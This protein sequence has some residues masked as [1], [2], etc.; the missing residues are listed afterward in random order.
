MPK[1][2]PLLLWMSSMLS[3][4]KA[5]PFM[6]SVDKKFLIS[7]LFFSVSFLRRSHFIPTALFRATN[8][9]RFSSLFL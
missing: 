3:S 6:V 8:H 4:V 7:S 5:K 9:L 2:R 1:E